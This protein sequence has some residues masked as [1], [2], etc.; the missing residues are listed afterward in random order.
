MLQSKTVTKTY[1]MMKKYQVKSA[2]KGA[3]SKYLKLLLEGSLRVRLYIVIL[4]ALLFASA[5]K[6]HKNKLHN[7]LNIQG[8][9]NRSG[10][11]SFGLDYFFGIP[12]SRHA[13]AAKAPLHTSLK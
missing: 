2:I 4:C 5:T 9:R 3:K 7:P 10:Q 1:T 12:V 8:W 11:S 13:S 6:T